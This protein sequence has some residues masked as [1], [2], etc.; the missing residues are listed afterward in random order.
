MAL[1][2]TALSLFVI[3]D[4]LTIEMDLAALLPEDSEV[5]RIYQT[6]HWDFGSFDFMLVVLETNAPGRE[7]MLIEA[8]R[9]L[10]EALDDPRFVRDV[11]YRLTPERLELGTPEGDARAVALLTDA[12][13][14]SIRHNLDNPD[15]FVRA[16]RMQLIAAPRRIQ[17]QMLQDPLFI[18][19]ELTEEKL[20]SG[21]LKVNLRDQYFM[22]EDG[23]M[24]LMLVWP[25]KASTDLSFAQD[26]STF[27]EETRRGIHIRNPHYGRHDAPA[28]E[29]TVRISFFGPHYESIADSRIVR[30]DFF[31]TSIISFVA[32]IFLFFFAFRRPEALLF[33]GIPLALG[34]LWTLGLTS[35]FIGRL[36]QVTMAFSAILIGLG[37]DFSVHLYNRYLEEVRQGMDNR[38]AV[39]LALQE[40][41]PGIIAGALT[42]ALAFFGMMTTSFVGFRELG[43]VSGLG[44][45]CCLTAVILVLPA[46]LALFG[47]GPVG[48]FTRRPMSALGLNRFHYTVTAYPRATLMAGLLICTYLGINALQ[49]RFEDDFSS[50]KQPSDDYVD[51][52]DRI[53]SSFQVPPNQLAVIVTGRTLEEALEK[54]DQIYRNIDAMQGL[55]N[56]IA[57]DSLRNYIPA[58]RTQRSQLERMSIQRLDVDRARVVD[59]GR[60]HG[61]SSAVFDPFFERINALQ[62]H[63]RQAIE[64][65]MTPVPLSSLEMREDPALTQIAQRYIYKRGD[66]E[67]RVIT[68][69]YPPP[70]TAD[71]NWNV[72]VPDAF[73]DQ[74]GRNLNQEPEVTGTVILQEEL[75][76]TIVRDL[77]KTV[78]LVLLS[79]VVLLF[80]FFEY[81]IVRALL[82]I[83]P[84]VFAMLCMLGTVHLLDMH[85]H[86]L[87]IIALPMI[88]G[89][90]VD[91][92][93]HMLQRY[94]EDDSR[95]LLQTVIHTGRAVIIT[96]LT[97]IFGFGSLIFAEF[98][99]VR[100]LGLFAILG[101]AFTLVAALL[102]LPAILGILSDPE[103]RYS[104]G[105]GDD[106]G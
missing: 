52:R 85:L 21:P 11:I 82:A 102:V 66:D 23:Q 31:K 20:K 27:L 38:D 56:W 99:G 77:A 6:A 69:I 35:I 29:Q 63:A 50:L 2:F 54:N 104:G 41:G 12:D 64:Q 13:W 89:I 58:P 40:T 97:T 61:L 4:R 18:F 57:W 14:R 83:V 75:R 36:T 65:G 34:V 10:S 72:F 46:I 42:T 105:K 86:Y 96:G 93:I 45:L 22:S 80:L 55:Y 87:N 26:F 53:L 33:V 8:A 44:V 24:L 95:N 25:V 49:V 37:I 59:A 100:E 71:H 28:Q 43:L 7:E 78:L 98:K 17:R 48:E 39:R 3:R 1:V 79:V 74:I 91:S 90:G 5:A 94:Y 67:W 73:R 84:V 103:T 60:R 76:K 47:S 106:I 16:L 68:R 32:V 30:Q 19:R 81:S 92:G 88:V 15:P 101:V 70:P 62:R 51:L 9:N